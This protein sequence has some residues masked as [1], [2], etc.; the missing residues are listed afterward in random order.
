[1]G[2]MCGTRSLSIYLGLPKRNGRCYGR[3][4]WGESVVAVPP[5]KDVDVTFRRLLLTESF[6]T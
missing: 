1:M 5:V 6:G 2:Q 3:G 4:D